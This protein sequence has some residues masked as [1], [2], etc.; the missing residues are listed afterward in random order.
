MSD[1]AIQQ[2]SPTKRGRG[3]GRGGA[4]RGAA[5]ARARGKPATGRRG[6]AKVY[7]NPRVQAAHERQR[8]LR[9]AWAAL[10]GHMKPALEELANRNIKLLK[11]NFDA[12]KEVDEYEDIQDFLVDR[13]GDRLQA[14]KELLDLQ[15]AND[16]RS[17][18]IS[19][20]LAKEAFKVWTSLCPILKPNFPRR[21]LARIFVCHSP[22]LLTV[23]PHFQRKLGEK[24]DEFNDALLN[25]LN[26]LQELANNGA[27]VDVSRNT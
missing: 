19:V 22:C 16:K 10:S 9:N 15:I 14:N 12:H 24:L 4:S 6:R 18:D 8:D 17:H 3:R 27:P 25:K 13:L 5:S 23:P 1:A 20:H 21:S 7:D 2:P 11:D 26:K